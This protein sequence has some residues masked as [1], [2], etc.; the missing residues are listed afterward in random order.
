L[1]KSLQK[2]LNGFS[3]ATLTRAGARRDKGAKQVPRRNRL[4]KRKWTRWE[5]ERLHLK[6]KKWWSSIEKLVNRLIFI[7]CGLREVLIGEGAHKHLKDAR[8]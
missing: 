8:L 6:Q 7:I 1:H 5:R 2:N 4:I 3:D